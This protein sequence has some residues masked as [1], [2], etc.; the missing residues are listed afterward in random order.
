MADRIQA[1]P[2]S[3]VLGMFADLLGYSS[4]YALLGNNNTTSSGNVGLTGYGAGQGI[5]PFGMRYSETLKDVPTQKRFGYFGAIP[6]E[7]GNPMTEL[8]SAFELDGHMISHP[9]LV[10]TLSADE[11]ALLQSGAEPT[12]NIYDKAQAWAM[13][14]IQKGQSPFATPQDVRFPLPEVNPMY[15]DPFADTTR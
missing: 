3:S 5:A 2:Q 6:D 10:P 8:S 13:N 15:L 11:I 12:Q 4:P 14:R 9:L 7:Q 1:T